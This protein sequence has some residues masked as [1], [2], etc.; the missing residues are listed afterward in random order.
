[1]E[2]IPLLNEI[3]A[4]TFDL[5]DTLWHNPPVIQNAQSKIKQHLLDEF[6]HFNPNSLD[7][8]FRESLILVR[9]KNPKLAHNLTELRRQSFE[10]LLRNHGYDP[11]QSYDLMEKFLKFRHEVSIYP[12]VEAC[13]QH[14]NGKYKLAALTNGNANVMRL[15]IGKYFDAHFSAEQVGVQK[16]KRRIFDH[17]SNALNMPHQ[18]ILHVGDNPVDDVKGALDSGF[19]AVWVNR[20]RMKWPL[21]LLGHKEILDLGQLPKLV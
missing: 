10:V 17:V 1:M 2:P 7:D 3:K 6:S 4:I 12:D 21:D 8:E 20:S 11:K 5:D 14:L 19:Q 18:N 15:E 16:P 9:A 13:L